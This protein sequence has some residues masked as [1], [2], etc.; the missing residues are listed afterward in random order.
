VLSISGLCAPLRPCVDM[1]AQACWMLANPWTYLKSMDAR[2]YD[3][4]L[5]STIIATLGWGTLCLAPAIYWIYWIALLATAVLDG[6]DDDL[7]MPLLTRAVFVEVHFLVMAV[8]TTLTYLTWHAVGERFIH[9]LQ[10]RYFIPVLL[11]LLLPL[12]SSAKVASSRFSR[13][14]VPLVAI[15]VVL[16]GVGATWQTLIARYYWR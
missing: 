1:K 2:I 7:R 4:Y 12:R 16:I 11:L 9:G 3:P 14:F 8:I 13:R 6:G 15:V 5:H 10:P